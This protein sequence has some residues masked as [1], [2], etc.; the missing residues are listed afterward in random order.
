MS[1]KFPGGLITKSPAAT[2]GAA[3]AGF[4]LEGGSAPGIWSL[5]QAMAL[6]K[7]GVWPARPKEKYLWTWGKNNNTGNLGDNTLVH[8][9][10]PVQIGAVTTWSQI[11]AGGN[12][13]MAIKADGTMWLWGDSEY[14]QLGN[15][16]NNYTTR[17]SS[18]VQIGA[19]T[20]WSSVGGGSS[21]TM[22]I[23]TD[24]TMWSWGYNVQGE[25]GSNT[26]VNRSSPVQIGALTTWSIMSAGNAHNLAI[27]N[28]GTMWGWGINNN[29]HLGDNTILFRSSPIQIG[30]LTTWSKVSAGTGASAAIKTD[31]TLWIW[32]TNITGQLGDNTIISRSSPIQVGLLTTWSQIASAGYHL[33]IK[34]D[35]TMWSWGYNAH[36]NLGDN[37]IILR[38][39]PIQIGSLTTWSKI[40]NSAQFSIATKTD[41]TLWTFGY[42]AAGSLG[43]GTTTYR[44]SPVQ[45]GA[46]VV[47]W[48]LAAG[49]NY[50]TMGLK[51]DGTM[52]LWGGNNYGQNGD[53]TI[54]KRSSPVQ[55]GANATWSK[56]AN[57]RHGMALKTDGSMW[58]WGRGDEGQIGDNAKLRRSSPV[59][60]GA[61][62]TWSQIDCGADTSL[63]LKTDGTMWA[64]GSNGQ[65]QLAQDNRIYR[66]SPVQIGA[67]TT[68]SKIDGAPGT[69][70][71]AIKTDGT[72]WAWC[73]NTGEG[74]TTTR[75][76]PIQ[77][78]ALT[79]W[80]LTSSSSYHCLAIKTNGTLWAWGFNISS[81][82][83]GAL[84]D[85]TTIDKSSP[86][87]IGAL[88]TWSLVS[89]NAYHSMALRT[90][91]TMWAWG[92]S[93]N[94]GRLGD[95]TTI[96]RS[97]PVQIGISTSWSK[98]AAGRN[99]SLA[100]ETN[101]TWYSWGQNT[102][103][104]TAGQ[105]G[106]NTEITRSSPVQI[107]FTP[108]AEKANWSKIAAGGGGHTLA[109]A[110][111]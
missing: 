40:D 36:G 6:K 103:F 111:E 108:A 73:G 64:W 102:L 29:G 68:W 62:T 91:G 105:L 87:Q 101:G 74:V 17:K 43:D 26:V 75:S 57:G 107:G 80:S 79:D 63:A 96:S 38:S 86:V 58:L 25:L 56:I 72:L 94:H 50:N 13:S 97:S 69:S 46:Q 83:Q 51:A 70:M 95:N 59:Q 89:A 41:N 18:P 1:S 84:G 49:G 20:T 93:P 10:S 53:D 7:A 30:A 76:S 109:I 44:S 104:E 37:T 12:H 99:H 67:L 11:A 60:L 32:G 48:S 5:D 82:G 24:G 2:V 90:D 65:G 31:G 85:N 78:G 92:K 110:V 21:H 77:I 45:V 16:T 22:A 14:G 81:T 55:I 71:K 8:R 23:K 34:T 35:G 28:D 47:A 4:G 15:N 54:L 9:S 42:G 52:W 106:D 3:D 19:L 100:I 98:I 61:L 27:K 88:T 66:S 39:S 33:A